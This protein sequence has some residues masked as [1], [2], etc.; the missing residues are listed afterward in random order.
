MAAS[1]RYYQLLLV[2]SSLEPLKSNIVLTLA[3]IAP[4]RISGAELTV[5]LGYSKKART[6]YRGVLDELK[7]KEFIIMEKQQKQYSIGINHNHPI[8][9]ELI[10]LCGTFGEDYRST[11]YDVLEAIP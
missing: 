9:K 7:T 8:M 11:L 4:A 3:H 5:M 6:L 1:E 10:E 2:I